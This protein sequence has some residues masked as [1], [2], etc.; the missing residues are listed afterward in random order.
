M[1]D[2]KNPRKDFTQIAFAVMQK[3][4]GEVAPEPDSLQ[5]NQAAVALGR[6]GGIKGG[7]ARKD[8]L[9]K[10]RRSQIAKTAAAARWKK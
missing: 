10:E 6:L 4:T 1:T 9:S 2:K 5:K 3:A 7:K 8:A